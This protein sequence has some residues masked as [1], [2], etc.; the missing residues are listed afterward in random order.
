VSAPRPETLGF[1]ESRY[2]GA[3]AE[4]LAGDASTRRF[5]R[6]TPPC[7]PSVVVMDYGSPFEGETDDLRLGRL[8][9]DAELPVAGLIDAVGP[10]GCLVL[11]DLGDRTLAEQIVAEPDEARVEAWLGKATELAVR[12]AVRGT[13]ALLRS[14]RA[15][16]PALDPERFRF[17]M[18]FF[19]EHYVGGLRGL[20]APRELRPLLH[21]LA[22]RAA[23][24]P[25]K[26][27][28]HRDFHTR[29]LMVRGDESLVM[30]DIQDARWGPDSYDLASLLRDAYVEIPEPVVDRLFEAYRVALPDSPPAEAFRGRFDLV[31][32]QRMLKALGTFGYQAARLGRERY[33][34][35]LPRTLTRLRRLLPALEATAELWSSLAETEILLPLTRE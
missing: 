25:G 31:S 3:R 9:R 21:R 32:A 19:L 7:G 12:I 34:E 22:E 24:S 15:S 13:P 4:P 23:D 29:N 16:G 30:V 2:P 18:D 14:E 6:V 17:E 27:L 28:C 1:V 35:G 11:E 5:L 20:E 8:F 33:L 10:A 26:V